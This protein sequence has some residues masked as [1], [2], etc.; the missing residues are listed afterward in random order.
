MGQLESR[1]PQ[2]EAAAPANANAARSRSPATF[3]MC[4]ELLGLRGRMLDSVVLFLRRPILRSARQREC[5]ENRDEGARP[6]LAR[7]DHSCAEV[8]TTFAA[9]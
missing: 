1:R 3:A 6:D 7:V 2:V 5:L 8:A 9:V 4:V